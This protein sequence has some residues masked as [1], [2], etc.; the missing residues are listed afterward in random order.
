M[1]SVL[2]YAADAATATK[3]Y[4]R[5][6]RSTTADD[7]A[8]WSSLPDDLLFTIMAS[9]DVPSLRRTGAVCKSWRAAHHA[10]RLPE[11][12]RAPC[13]LYACEEY[14]PN[15]AALYC[16][17]TGATFRVPFPGPPHEKRGFAFACQGG[18]VF[19]TD[20][21]GNPYLLNPVTGAQ[22]VL[23][24][25]KTIYGSD[26]FYDDH[27]KHV[28]PAAPEYGI[29]KPKIKWA[30]H[31]EF[32][33]VASP[34]PPMP[35]DKR[36]TRVLPKDTHAVGDILYNDKDGLFYILYLNGSIGT[37]DLSGPSPSLT[38][39]MRREISSSPYHTMYLAL[40]SSG[41]LLQVERKWSPKNI[42][43]KYHD[44]YRDINLAS[45]D[46]QDIDASRPLEMAHRLVK[47]ASTVQLLVFKVDIE[48][49]KL[50]KLRD[51]GDH[52]LFL[53]LNS[54]VCL[55]TKDFPAFEP[56]SVYLTDACLYYGP[57]LRKVLCI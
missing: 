34:P 43:L 25:L 54:A 55:P 27:G 32:L 12:E 36:W 52:A 22:A 40:G 2:S 38:M 17:A 8:G 11:L 47:K 5:Q 51:I 35:G 1:G 21:I 30:R 13:L 50:V 29:M 57:M 16:P 14:G 49:R 19:T 56:N 26:K 37:L 46:D 23:P 53:G 45:E 44:T 6:R 42:S 9:L 33:G 7:V 20:E 48:R 24:P 15:Y 41:E 10:F 31:R 39:I 18:W 28:W 3:N 4:V